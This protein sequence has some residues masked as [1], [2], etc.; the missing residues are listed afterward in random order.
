MCK[1]LVYLARFCSLPALSRWS[2][3]GWLHTIWTMTSVTK[4]IS[5]ALSKTWMLPLC[6]THRMKQDPALSGTSLADSENLSS[7]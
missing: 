4:S 3:Q 6:H 2:E 7:M 1:T 5:L